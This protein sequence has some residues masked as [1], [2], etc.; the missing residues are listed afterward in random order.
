MILPASR[1]SICSCFYCHCP[2]P[3]MAPHAEARCRPCPLL[4][5]A[6]CAPLSTCLLPLVLFVLLVLPLAGFDPFSS[7][8][9]ENFTSPRCSAL[10]ALTLPM[11]AVHFK[12]V[13]LEIH[14]SHG[15]NPMCLSCL[16][17]LPCL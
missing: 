14:D 12:V 13:R 3:P 6:S 10:L 1:H 16:L 7:C 15:F 8:T 17:F 2:L 11:R 9:L 5:F 4:I